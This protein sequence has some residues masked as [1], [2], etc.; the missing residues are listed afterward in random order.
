MADHLVNVFASAVGMLGSSPARAHELFREITDYDES[1][2]DAW[3]G[4]IGCGDMD[5]VTLFRAWYSRKNFGRLAGAAEVSVNAL[6]ARVPIG[7]EFGNITYPVNSPLAVTMG[8]AVSQ[9]IFAAARLGIADVLAVSYFHALKFRPKEP[10][11]EGRDRFCLS[12][13][14]Y[15]IALYAANRHLGADK[16]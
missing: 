5:R 2:C 1:A 9:T 3:V 16:A 4:R 13:G 11:W 6:G 14:H 8:F 12:I 7:G 15:A 10:E